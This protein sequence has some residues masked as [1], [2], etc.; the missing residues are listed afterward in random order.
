MKRAYEAARERAKQ[1]VGVQQYLYEYPTNDAKI[2]GSLTAEFAIPAPAPGAPI[3]DC[4]ERLLAID[5]VIKRVKR[6]MDTLKAPIKAYMQNF[7]V[8][9]INSAYGHVELKDMR[10]FEVNEALIP[11][12]ILSAYRAAEAAA[13]RYATP[14]ASIPTMNN[15]TP[16]TTYNLKR[17][18][19]DNLK[20]EGLL[21]ALGL[22]GSLGVEM[23]L[24]VQC[25]R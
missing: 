10:Q 2:E 9:R 18:P 19:A 6:V 13:Q 12:D 3:T 22:M 20:F 11:W 7:G 15:G 25:L 23:N 1:C 24:A 21:Q 17:V 14:A 4:L 5:V 8:K 16:T